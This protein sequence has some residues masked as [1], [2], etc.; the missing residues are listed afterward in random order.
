ME[1]QQL[2]NVNPENYLDIIKNEKVNVK[3]YSQLGLIILKCNRNTEYKYDNHQWLRYCRGAIIDYK[4]KRVVCIPPLKASNETDLYSI[5]NRANCDT[6]TNFERL[7]QPLI[8]GTMINMFYHNDEWM[9]STRS[10]IGAKNSWDGKIPFNKMFKDI[11]GTEW[12]DR[13]NKDNCASSLNAC[14]SV[15]G[16]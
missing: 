14:F 5:L 15:L 8:D 12:F 16:N 11:H 6:E 7:Y 3:K 10:N 4:N 13:L 9:I 2:I 1:L